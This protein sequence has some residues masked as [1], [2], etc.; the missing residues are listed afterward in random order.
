M[1]N[2]PILS[3]AP[4]KMLHQDVANGN[5]VLLLSMINRHSISC[6]ETTLREWKESKDNEWGI[7]LYTLLAIVNA[8]FIPIRFFLDPI[9]SK[10]VSKYCMFNSSLWVP[11]RI[12]LR[13]LATDICANYGYKRKPAAEAMGIKPARLKKLMDPNNNDWG[14]TEALEFVRWLKLVDK[15]MSEYIDDPNYCAPSEDEIEQLVIDERYGTTVAEDIPIDEN[16]G[17][18]RELQ[19]RHVIQRWQEDMKTA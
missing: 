17:Y 19:K 14:N 12:N 15:D 3:F 2:A 9:I 7:R 11:V 6:S 13:Q 18:L 16:R 1:K 5:L 4:M 10:D 8:F